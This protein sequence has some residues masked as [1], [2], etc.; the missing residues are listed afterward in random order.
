[1]SQNP[2]GWITAHDK[3]LLQFGD[4]EPSPIVGEPLPGIKKSRFSRRPA[5]TMRCC[6]AA[7]GQIK[8]SDKE[9]MRC[10][11]GGA[12]WQR[13]R[14]SA[15]TSCLQSFPGPLRQTQKVQRM[16]RSQSERLM[17]WEGA[18]NGRSD[19]CGPAE[20]LR[21]R[22]Q[23]AGTHPNNPTASLARRLLARICSIGCLFAAAGR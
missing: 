18:V 16:T 13:T 9:K 3:L 11:A 4:W 7:R 14:R 5:M 2:A 12:P 19:V 17:R 22:S 1:M 20:E 10:Q 8:P 21:R 23:F 6:G 15:R